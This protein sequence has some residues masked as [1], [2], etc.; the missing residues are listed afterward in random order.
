ML[1]N[2][3]QVSENACNTDKTEVKNIHRTTVIAPLVYKTVSLI[4]LS[5][6][7]GKGHPETVIAKFGA[8]CLN[9]NCR[10]EAPTVGCSTQKIL[11]MYAQGDKSNHLLAVWKLN[12]HLLITTWNTTA[13]ARNRTP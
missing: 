10:H 9:P 2:L 8:V 4:T 7:S 6:A 3:Q 13:R 5:V 12:V 11:L 1:A